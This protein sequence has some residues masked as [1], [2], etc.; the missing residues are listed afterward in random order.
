MQVSGDGRFGPSKRSPNLWAI[1][2]CWAGLAP[3]TRDLDV[4]RRLVE[5]KSLALR[6]LGDVG[7]GC[8]RQDW[9]HEAA[10]R[11]VEIA[12]VQA[13]PF[14][15]WRRSTFRPRLSLNF[16]VFFCSAFL[17]VGVATSLVPMPPSPSP[18]DRACLDAAASLWTTAAARIC[19][20]GGGRIRDLGLAASSVMDALRLEV[21]VD[22]PFVWRSPAGG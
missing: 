20:E 14:S 1:W 5:W 3:C 13:L 6:D 15:L 17:A 10:N 19:G 9:H 8:Q 21:V 11:T 16:A 22:G 12:Y 2:P 4:A 7:P 18:R